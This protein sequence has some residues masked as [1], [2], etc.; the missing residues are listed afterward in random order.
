MD[1]EVEGQKASIE[2][3]HAILVF[4]PS[5]FFL[6]I[7]GKGR[8]VEREVGEGVQAPGKGKKNKIVACHCIQEKRSAKKNQSR[9]YGEMKRGRAYSMYATRDEMQSKEGERDRKG[10]NV[11]GRR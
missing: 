7:E 2:L 1:F 6:F 8:K 9:A 11:V 10:R 4:C 3:P 5:E